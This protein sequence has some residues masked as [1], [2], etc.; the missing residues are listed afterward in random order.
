M[1]LVGEWKWKRDCREVR[2]E[3]FVSRCKSG[4]L[5][6]VGYSLGVLF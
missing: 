4:I 6:V 2:E 1:R 3:E 5:D